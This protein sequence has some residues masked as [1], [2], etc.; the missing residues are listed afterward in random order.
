MH[1]K[2]WSENLKGRDDMED[3]DMDRRIITEWIVGKRWEMVDWIHLA[4]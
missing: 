3:L 4:G 1:T 2:F